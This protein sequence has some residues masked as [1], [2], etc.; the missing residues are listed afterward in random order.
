MAP[1]GRTLYVVI[2]G[3]IGPDVPGAHLVVP[4]TLATGIA[5]VPIQLGSG[6]VAAAVTPDGRTLF[7]AGTDDK[8]TL[9]TAATG[10]AGRAFRVVPIL[11]QVRGDAAALAVTP[12]G[13]TLYVADESQNAVAAITL[14][15]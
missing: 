9:I 14:T 10:T 13:R 12:N 6:P 5:G 4:L 11:G 2:N 7:V 15:P 3:D 8:V 1:D